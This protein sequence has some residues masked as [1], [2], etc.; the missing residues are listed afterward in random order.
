MS[1]EFRQYLFPHDHPRVAEVRGMYPYSCG[2]SS[3]QPGTFT[4]GLVEGW[5]PLYLDTFRG[6]TEDGGSVSACTRSRLSPR[7]PRSR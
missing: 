2:E 5:T 3:K 4:G 6:V 1:G 7:R